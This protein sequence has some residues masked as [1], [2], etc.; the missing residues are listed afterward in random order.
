MAPRPGLLT[1]CGVQG[2][3]APAGVWG[4]APKPYAAAFFA[5]VASARRAQETRISPKIRGFSTDCSG[6]PHGSPPFLYLAMRRLH[7]PVLPQVGH[8]S[9][10]RVKVW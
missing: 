1:K 4:R 8:T 6:E 5:S 9:L 2:P 7:M 10:R 3:Q